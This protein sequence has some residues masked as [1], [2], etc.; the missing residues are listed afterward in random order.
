MAGES[1]GS[2][3]KKA[4]DLTVE[5]LDEEGLREKLSSGAPAPSSEDEQ[6]DLLD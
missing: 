2:K 4:Q 5:V 6:G 3:L 1:P